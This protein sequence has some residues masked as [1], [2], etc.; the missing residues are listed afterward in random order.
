LP[1]RNSIESPAGDFE[2]THFEFLNFAAESH[3][4][5]FDEADVLR[6]LI[7]GQ[8]ALQKVRISSSSI[9]AGLIGSCHHN[10]PSRSSGMPITCAAA[11]NI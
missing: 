3:R 1:V 11:V 2:L 4:I 5:G 9:V 10:L 8:R 7:V 6:D